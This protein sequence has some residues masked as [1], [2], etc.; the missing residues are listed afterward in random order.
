MILQE[1]VSRVHRIF[2]VSIKYL[3]I[4]AIGHYLLPSTFDLILIRLVDIELAGLLVCS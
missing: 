2:V 3:I 1:A 4:R